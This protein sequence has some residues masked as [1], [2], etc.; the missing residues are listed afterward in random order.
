MRLICSFLKGSHQD[1]HSLFLNVNYHNDDDVKNFV[2]RN[3][4]SHDDDDC[5]D[6]WAVQ[7]FSQVS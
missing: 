2:N 6:K 7:N 5:K 4:F 3:Q 1:L